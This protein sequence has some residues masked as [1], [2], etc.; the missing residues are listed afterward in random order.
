MA[1]PEIELPQEALAEFHKIAT[2]GDAAFDS[3][4][5]AIKST[6]ATLRGRQFSKNVAEKVPLIDK[7]DVGSILGA[8]VVLYVIRRK[9]DMTLSPQEIAGGIVNSPLFAESKQFTPTLRDVLSERIVKLL[10][11]DKSIGVTSKALD[12]MTEHERVYCNA[13]ILSDIRPVFATAP[14]TADGAVIIHNLQIGFHFNGKHREIYIALDSGDIKQ[15]KAI[16]ERAEKKDTALQ[17]ILT[18]SRIPYLAP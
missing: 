16:I 5:V 11:C 17:S 12:V 2:V 8:A 3:L 10:D 6:D 1:L 18:Q 4:L 13:R 14:E 9:S 7:G 15:L